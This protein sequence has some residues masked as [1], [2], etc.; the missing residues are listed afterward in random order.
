MREGK[1][2]SLTVDSLVSLE[3][4]NQTVETTFTFVTTWLLHFKGF[5]S[6]NWF[7]DIL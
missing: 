2:E 4:K 1:K 3:Q 7:R 6:P 5:L